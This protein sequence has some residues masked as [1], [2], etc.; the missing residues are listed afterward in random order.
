MMTDQK[1]PPVQFDLSLY[2]N[3]DN[4]FSQSEMD[5]VVNDYVCPVCQ[6]DL[7]IG[8]IPNYH[9]VVIACPIHG[10]VCDVGRITRNTVNIENEYGH[11]AYQ[12]VIRNLPDLWGE[13]IEE[14]MERRKA[15]S[16]LHSHVCAICGGTLYM[17]LKQG[18]DLVDLEC[19]T[20]NR[21][22]YTKAGGYIEKSKFIYHFQTMKAWEKAN[23]RS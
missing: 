20:H 17:Y 22:R 8:Y 11:K 21:H 19:Q 6:S 7:S 4:T 16:M 3:E 10:N 14:G 12:T 2:F 15:E 18:S 23:K 9:R 1:T 5:D 13:L